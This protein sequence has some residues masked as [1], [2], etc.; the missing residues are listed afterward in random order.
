MLH[1]TIIS[2]EKAEMLK[3]HFFSEKLQADLSDIKEAVYSSEMKSLLQIS[4]EN[5]QNL[6][7][8]QQVLSILKINN[9]F[10]IFLQVMNK[11]FTEAVAKLT[12][13]CWELLYYLM[14]FHKARM[15]TLHK[16]KKDDYISL[17][18]WRLIMLLSTVDKVIEAVTVSQLW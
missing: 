6:M 18:F 4:A 7:I 12:Q 3:R 5:I 17:R 10:N 16:Q 2:Q 9:I 11:F 14:Q 15:M 13:I 1:C 8:C